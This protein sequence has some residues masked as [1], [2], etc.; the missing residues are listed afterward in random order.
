MMLRGLPLARAPNE[1]V[2]LGVAIRDGT[3]PAAIDG[4]ID[5]L[6]QLCELQPGYRRAEALRVQ[7]YAARRV[8]LRRPGERNTRLTNTLL[9]NTL[10]TRECENPEEEE[11]ECGP[12]RDG[13]ARIMSSRSANLR[14]APRTTKQ[15][16]RWQTAGFP[17]R[18]NLAE[19][20]KSRQPDGIKYSRV[21]KLLHVS[22]CN[23][24]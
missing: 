18:S 2:E 11:A 19:A 20:R 9:T 8:R 1:T 3:L 5:A 21:L 13:C 6:P 22:N 4:L 15:R 14:T 16:N 23:D 7:R 10:L 17:A 24:R 12:N